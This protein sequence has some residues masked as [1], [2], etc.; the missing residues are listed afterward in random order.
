MYSTQIA[1]L[2]PRFTGM[3]LP[4]AMIGVIGLTLGAALLTIPALLAGIA[5]LGM[6]EMANAANALQS[7]T[8]IY[9]PL[10]ADLGGEKVLVGFATGEAYQNPMLF[11]A[12]APGK[13]T[14]STNR[15]Q[16]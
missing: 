6:A 3:E 4:I 9:S 15:L 12:T 16:P 13:Y 10:Y 5:I 14:R 11:G 1:D 7:K 8:C 2:M